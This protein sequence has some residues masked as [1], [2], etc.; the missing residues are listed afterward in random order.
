MKNITIICLILLQQSCKLTTH[1]NAVIKG[2]GLNKNIQKVYLTSA[3]EWDKFLDSANCIDGSFTLTYK[4]T[5]RFEPFLASL[6][7]L[8]SAKKITQFYVKN[9]FLI[10]KTG[11]NS[12]N[13]AFMLD[14]GI[15][16]IKNF[17]NKDGHTSAILN[18][19]MENQLFQN[20][21]WQNFGYIRDST[22]VK[23]FA[24][25][26]ALIKKYP[27]SYY[28]LNKITQ[29]R[30]HYSKKQLTEILQNFSIPIRNS[31]SSLSL[32]NY[33]NNMLLPNDKTPELSLVSD[34]GVVI[35]G[36]DRRAKLNM[37]VFWASWCGPCRLEIPDLKKIRST[38][39]S[40]DFYMASISIDE[41][42]EYWQNALK[43]EKMSWDQFIV[44]EKDMDIIMARYRFSSIPLVVFIDQNGNEIKRFNGY[45]P[46]R[47]SEY[48]SFIAAHN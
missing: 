28:F 33:T 27:D 15:S 31:K 22:D 32:R 23:R 14:Y 1:N 30:E 17:E 6:C 13:S 46:N 4:P 8:D 40:K 35:K 25:N 5:E 39:L 10:K 7:Y 47:T 45:A 41:N 38:V 43:Y 37:L 36:I 20:F 48:L 18:S 24:R 12:A 29:F 44:D 11:K 16:V 42:K 26:T 3:V 2:I 9:E 34:K 21:E 19:G